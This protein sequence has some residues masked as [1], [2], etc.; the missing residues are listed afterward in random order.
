MNLL[1]NV[2]C[3]I[4]DQ[5]GVDAID[6]TPPLYDVIDV[7]A[8]EVLV[9]GS[10]SRH[11]SPGPTVE[12]E[13]CG[14]TVTIDESAH[15]SIGDGTEMKGD[16]RHKPDLSQA[17]SPAAIDKRTQVM[18]DAGH[19][20]AARDRPFGER[21]DGLLEVIRLDLAVEYATLSYVDGDSCVFEAV[22]VVDAADIEPGDVVPIEE[23]V[24]KRV[25]E[26]EQ[27]IVL[28]DVAVDAPELAGSASE[29]SSFIG[30]P[31]FVDGDVYGTFC[32]YDSEP[33]SEKFTEWD[34]GLIEVLA[35]WVSSELEQRAQERSLHAATNERPYVVN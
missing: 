2:V 6:L 31:V 4:A 29:L 25:I 15:V 34:L 28:T 30:V 7:E 27:S 33:R 21:L 5:E 19:V 12:F 11:N 23:T 22:D 13:Y 24:C 20:L 14:Y 32:F 1:Q 17:A 35:N 26:T 9:T 16:A 10:P 18:R 3:E 8:L